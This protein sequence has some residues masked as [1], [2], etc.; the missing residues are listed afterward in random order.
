VVAYSS[1]G[2][3]LMGEMIAVVGN[4]LRR[5]PELYQTFGKVVELKL[6]I[7]RGNDF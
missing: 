6:L 1:A 3:W 4:E 5:G 2:E 7:L